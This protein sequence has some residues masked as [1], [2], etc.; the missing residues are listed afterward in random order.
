[1]V[2]PAVQVGMSLDDFIRLYDKEGSFEIINGERIPLMPTVA[3]HG[4]TLKIIYFALS[5]YVS[6]QKLGEAISELPFVFSY[7]SNWVTGSL[8]PDVMYYTAERFAT[9][10]EVNPD[11]KKKPYILV[12]DLVVEVVSPNDNL[13]ELNEKVDLYLTNGVRLVWV[14]NPNKE[15]LSIYTLVS[16]QPFTKQQTTLKVG[17]TLSGGEIIPGFEITVASLFE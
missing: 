8:V 3:G 10:K 7:L 13:G 15:N 12:P 14:V 17:D 4:Y 11:W 2:T 16:L 9:Y 1:M 5:L 6:A